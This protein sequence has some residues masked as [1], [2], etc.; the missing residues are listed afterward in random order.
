MRRNALHLSLPRCALTSS[1]LRYTAVWNQSM[2]QSED[3]R[4]GVMSGLKKTK[5]RYEKL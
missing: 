1:G 3:F 5:P 2:V 4:R